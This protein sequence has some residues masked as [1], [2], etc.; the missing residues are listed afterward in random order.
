MRHFPSKQRQ[1]RDTWFGMG[2]QTLVEVGGTITSTNADYFS[3]SLVTLVN[4]DFNPLL[5][6]GEA[7][8]KL[9]TDKVNS[10]D[11]LKEFSRKYP[12]LE[13]ETKEQI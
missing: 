2:L 12:G 4:M 10:L 13:M 1:E 9:T 5:Q 7:L 6:N 8:E 3:G 11:E